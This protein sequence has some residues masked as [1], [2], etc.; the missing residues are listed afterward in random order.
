MSKNPTTGTSIG[1][2]G[3]VVLPVEL[4]GTV[5]LSSGTVVLLVELSGTVELSL[6]PLLP[7]RGVYLL[8]IAHEFSRI[9]LP[10]FWFTHSAICSS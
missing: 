1:R 8:Q 6:V 3:S 9:M 5:E 7:G 10:N 4:L 2:L